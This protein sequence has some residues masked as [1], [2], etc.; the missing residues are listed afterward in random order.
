MGLK[1][2]IPYEITHATLV[3]SNTAKNL[4]K[5]C[6]RK[7]IIKINEFICFMLSYILYLRQHIKIKQNETIRIYIST[8]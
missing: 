1:H 5:D 8:G 2:A 6:L 7:K 3:S 4:K